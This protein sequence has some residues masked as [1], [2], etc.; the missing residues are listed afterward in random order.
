MFK[1]CLCAVAIALALSACASDPAPTEQL[2]LS[3]Q[4]VSQAKA[5]GIDSEQLSNLKL[6]EEKQAAAQLAMQDGAFKQARVLSEQAELDARLAQ[7]QF[8]TQKSQEQLDALTLRIDRLRKQLG[9][10]P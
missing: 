5:L 1:R 2:R 4:A 7:A 3:D 10:L 8:L 9:D 6:A